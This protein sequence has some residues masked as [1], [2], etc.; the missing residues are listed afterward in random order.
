MIEKPT[1]TV[2]QIN[3]YIK[4][5]FMRNEAL[6]MVLVRGEVSNC[7][8]H[9]SGHIYFTIKDF[10]GQ[11]ACVMFSG[12]RRGLSF[13]LQEGQS[14]IVKGSIQVY[15]RD[16]KYQLYASEIA[17]DGVGRLYEQIE[18]LKKRLQM[19]GL[20]DVAHKKAIPCY[21]TKIGIVTAMTGAAIQD[22][23]QI[24]RRRNPYVQL[25]LYPALVQGDG[26]VSSIVNGI[27]C[28]DRKNCDVLIVG[29][30]GGSIEDLMA[31]NAEEVVRAVAECVTPVISAVGHETDVTLIDF[32]SDLR[33]PTPSAAAE[34][35]VFEYARLE[36]RLAAYHVALASSMVKKIE[37]TRKRL[38]DIERFYSYVSPAAKL[39]EHRMN[40]LQMEQRLQDGMK[41]KQTFAKHRIALY[42][43]RLQG[44]SPLQ[45]L[46]HGFAYV[47]DEE[48]K[49]LVSIK[50]LTKSSMVQVTLKDG[51]F[52]A[53]VEEIQNV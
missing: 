44:A 45:K 21:A 35:A 46:S 41:R 47:T 51:N 4:Q 3:A 26:A 34:L 43:Q 48:K 24:T 2:S 8:Y 27:R 6:Q 22:M 18:Q 37:Q 25:V 28:L 20:F 53:R 52:S 32:V 40:L 1:F 49:P 33:A 12:Q 36:E 17:L 29:R 30:V 11:L 50:G 31:F 16:G 7:K 19:E 15:E 13:S 42:A 5:M 23:I 10:A 9:T 38:A 39:K 14:V